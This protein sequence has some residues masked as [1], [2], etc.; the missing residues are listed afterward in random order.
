MRPPER[1]LSTAPPLPGTWAAPRS[2]QASDS[3][4]RLPPTQDPSHPCT[5][6]VLPLYP[7]TR[8]HVPGSQSHHPHTGT[9]LLTSC[10]VTL[11][12][13]YLTHTACTIDN[14]QTD[15]Q[16]DRHGQSGAPAM[17]EPAQPPQ[18]PPQPARALYLA[19]RCWL[20]LPVGLLAIDLPSLG[21]RRLGPG[22]T[23]GQESMAGQGPLGATSLPGQQCCIPALTCRPFRR[24][25][26]AVP[27]ARLRDRLLGK[28]CRQELQPRQDGWPALLRAQATQARPPPH[29]P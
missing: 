8:T 9:P 26:G 16:N 2:V 22:C 6:L 13:Y 21:H 27:R 24:L 4:S 1:L 11:P 25:D 12:T 28:H 10:H 23:W 7:S 17:A 18:C 29:L 14:T 3:S 5:H 19:L 15:R 20:Q